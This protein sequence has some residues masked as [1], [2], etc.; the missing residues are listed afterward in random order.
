MKH[1]SAYRHVVWDWNGTLFDDVSLCVSVINGMLRRRGMERVTVQQYRGMFGFPVE[2]YYRS[3]GFNFEQEPFEVLGLEFIEEYESR[4]LE[5]GLYDGVEGVL[6]QMRDTGMS[7]SLLSAYQQ[8][9]LDELA[10]HF[11]LAHFF[12]DRIGLEDCYAHGKLDTGLRWIKESGMPPSSILLIGDTLHDLE[13]A[14]AMGV[15]CSLV[16]SGH[17]TKKRLQSSGKIV[18]DSIR[19]IANS[20]KHGTG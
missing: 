6:M 2:E 12:V 19:G 7:Q 15:D 17:Q 13:V 9:K 10:Q 16:S 4:R 5:A 3:L 1:F 20:L 8:D 14:D 18:F 11:S